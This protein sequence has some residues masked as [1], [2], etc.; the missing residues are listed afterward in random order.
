MRDETEEREIPAQLRVDPLF[1]VHEILHFNSSG[2]I[3]CQKRNEEPVPKCYLHYYYHGKQRN[4]DAE[5]IPESRMIPPQWESPAHRE[6]RAV[7]PCLT[8]GFVLFVVRAKS[9]PDRG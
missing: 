4:P 3:A 5:S 9:S 2:R 6:S 1:L 8:R 7:K